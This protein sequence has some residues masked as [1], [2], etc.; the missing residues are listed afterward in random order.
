M[1]QSIMSQL[2]NVAG[3]EKPEVRPNERDP[4]VPGPRSPDPKLPQTGDP[5]KLP[6]DM[7]DPPSSDPAPSP[8]RPPSPTMNMSA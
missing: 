2:L 5:P 6:P 8:V 1:F 3:P 7:T 4:E